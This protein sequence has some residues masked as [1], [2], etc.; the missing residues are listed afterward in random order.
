MNIK[1]EKS[2]YNGQP[3]VG[4]IYKRKDMQYKRGNYG[5]KVQV[6]DIKDDVKLDFAKE[7]NLS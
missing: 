5:K 7:Q 4:I 2:I 3:R 1:I 6:G